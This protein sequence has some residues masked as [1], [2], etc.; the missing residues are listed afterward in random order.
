MVNVRSL[1]QGSVEGST[2]MEC[3]V[4]LPDATHELSFVAVEGQRVQSAVV[5]IISDCSPPEVV[6]VTVPEDVDENGCVNAREKLPENFAN[7][8]T[9]QVRSNGLSDGTRVEAQRRLE[10]ACLALA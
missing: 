10:L 8:F 4:S 2:L 6:S 1:V 7:D 9:V 3:P 5:S